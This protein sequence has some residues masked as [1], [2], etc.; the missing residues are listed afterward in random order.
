MKKECIY[1]NSIISSS[2]PNSAHADKADFNDHLSQTTLSYPQSH[3]QSFI[4]LSRIMVSS[5]FSKFP[6]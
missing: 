3:P 5:K 4:I 1:Y 6:T 2:D